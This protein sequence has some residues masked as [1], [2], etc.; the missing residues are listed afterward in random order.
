MA[1]VTV[2]TYSQASFEM[3]YALKF[4]RIFTLFLTNFFNIPGL[5]IGVIITFACII[6][7]KTMTGMS[8]IYPLYPFDAKMFRRKILRVRLPHSY[9]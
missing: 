3:G 7:N 1:V 2:G 6:F 8:Y 4:F 9:K 5:V